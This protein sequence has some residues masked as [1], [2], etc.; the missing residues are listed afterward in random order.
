[1]HSQN[2]ARLA[3]KR[4]ANNNTSPT[5]TSLL[6]HN[7]DYISHN[8][9]VVWSNSILLEGTMPTLTVPESKDTTTSS[10]MCCHDVHVHDG[11]AASVLQCASTKYALTLPIGSQKVRMVP[12]IESSNF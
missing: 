9:S 6:T 1:M 10:A 2:Q 8:G 11:I 5:L 4:Q 3:C 12:I 7:G